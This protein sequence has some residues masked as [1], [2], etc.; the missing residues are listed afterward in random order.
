MS[1]FPRLHGSLVPPFFPDYGPVDC[2]IFGEAPG[3]RGADQSGIPFWGD[4][5]GIPLYRALERADRAK[6]PPEAWELWDGQRFRQLQI[7]PQLSRVALSN[8]YPC[9]PTDDGHRFRTPKKKELEAEANLR[10]LDAELK[11]AEKLGA[12]RVI[13]LGRCAGLTVGP[14][15]EDRGWQWIGLPHPSSQGLLMSA[16]GKGKGLRLSD[17]RTQWEENLVRALQTPSTHSGISPSY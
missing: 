15:A 16:P 14:L 12:L 9:C 8:A 10:R 17:L 1:A 3:P 5:A 4:A 2:L 11:A 6:I 7:Q 13:T